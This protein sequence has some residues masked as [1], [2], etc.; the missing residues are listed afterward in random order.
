MKLGI[1]LTAFFTT[2]LHLHIFAM[3]N[4]QAVESPQPKASEPISL[5]KVE[6]ARA[7]YDQ[8][9]YDLDRTMAQK[10]TALMQ[11]LD[12]YKK[13][14]AKLPEEEQ[15][16]FLLEAEG[17]QAIHEHVVQEI[18][19]PDTHAERCF[20]KTLLGP[21]KKNKMHIPQTAAS[22]AS[23]QV[24]ASSAPASSDSCTISI[25][26]DSSTPKNDLTCKEFKEEEDTESMPL[27]ALSESIKIARKKKQPHLYSVFNPNDVP[28]L[29]PSPILHAWQ[30]DEQKK[31]PFAQKIPTTKRNFDNLKNIGGYHE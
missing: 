29:P 28:D 24:S 21:A 7:A 10:I 20:A 26:L 15:Q 2:V 12:T 4:Q 18:L 22:S 6:E 30:K 16:V 31:L 17:S 23:I 9:A 27:A 1:H 11:C 14:I 5:K 25:K 19:R 3:E 8:A 13:E